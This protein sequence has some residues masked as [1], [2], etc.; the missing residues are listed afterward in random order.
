M[1]LEFRKRSLLAVSL[2]MVFKAVELDEIIL[3][4]KKEEHLSMEPGCSNVGPRALPQS[5]QQ[6]YVGNWRKRT[7]QRRPP[8][9]STRAETL[10]AG[11]RSQQFFLILPRQSYRE[12]NG[13]PLHYFCLENPMGRGAWWA[14]VH[15]VPKSRTRLSDFTFMH[16]RRKWRP[17]PVFLPGESQGRRSLVGCCLWG[18]TESDT[19]EVT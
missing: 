1:S 17:T 13:T 6:V 15:G 4:M 19:T 5:A 9:R 2:W 10:R 11:P 12:G 16:W 8:P 3:G 7:R 18:H 14:S